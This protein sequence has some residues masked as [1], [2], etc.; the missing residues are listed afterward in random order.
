MIM[1][2]IIIIIIVNIITT[3]FSDISV[4]QQKK[5]P[6][7]HFKLNFSV[8]AVFINIFSIT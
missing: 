3:S 7:K 1:I 6:T 4:L 8:F 5:W 2:V